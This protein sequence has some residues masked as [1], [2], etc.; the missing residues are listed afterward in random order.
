MFKKITKE[1]KGLELIH[2]DSIDIII[3]YLQGKVT[4]YFILSKK[5]NKVHLN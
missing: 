4:G 5:P 2:M 1:P 3:H